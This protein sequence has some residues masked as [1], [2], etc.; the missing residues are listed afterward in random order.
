MEG[1]VHKCCRVPLPFWLPSTFCTYL[2]CAHSCMHGLLA[3][4]LLLL[5]ACAIIAA[6]A[7][8]PGR[9]GRRRSVLVLGHGGGLAH[10]SCVRV[11]VGVVCCGCGFGTN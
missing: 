5:L 9:K 4:L 3:S 11:C 8:A 10:V 1:W 2:L 6:A 7:A